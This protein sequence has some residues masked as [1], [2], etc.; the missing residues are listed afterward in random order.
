MLIM[1]HTGTYTHNDEKLKN[2]IGTLVTKSEVSK[3][4]CDSSRFR[5]L[6]DLGFEILAKIGFPNIVLSFFMIL[7]LW[8]P[9]FGQIPILLRVFFGLMF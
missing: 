2:E 6:K 3:D 5:K 9:F 8:R 7:G 4:T 1:N